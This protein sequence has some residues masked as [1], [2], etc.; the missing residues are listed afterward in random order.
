MGA[1][2]AI[3]PRE[4]IFVPHHPKEA[5]EKSS[6]GEH[7]ARAAQ[8][9]LPRRGGFA[10][11]ADDLQPAHHHARS[12]AAEDGEER[13]ILQ[14]DDGKSGG[15]NGGSQFAQRKLPAER[16]EE[17]QESSIRKQQAGEIDQRREASIIDRC[18]GMKAGQRLP[19]GFGNL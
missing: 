8:E 11:K 1:R 16:P 3:V 13:E 5:H 4:F 15:V 12:R 17:H 10:G 2:E 18:H 19:F 9:H 14:I 7:V 6:R